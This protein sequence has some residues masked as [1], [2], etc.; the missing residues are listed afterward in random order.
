MADAIY[1]LC[2]YHSYHHYLKEEGRKEVDQITWEKVGE[3]INEC[4]LRC[5]G[6]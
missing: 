1:A 6:W 4:Y 3:R 2:T 5:L